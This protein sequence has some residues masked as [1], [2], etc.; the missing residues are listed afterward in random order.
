MEGSEIA[1]LPETALTQ[2]P[3]EVIGRAQVIANALAPIIEKQK[4]FTV[5]GGKKHVWVEGWTTMLAMLNVFPTVDF[6]RKLE[7][8]DE[9][10]YEA[11]VVLKFA[12][13]R[14][15]AAEHMCSNREAGKSGW[16]EY[17]VKSMAQTRAVGKAAR[18]SFSWIMSLAGYATTPAEEMDAA[19]GSVT[20]PRYQFGP[21][22]TETTGTS[23]EV[24]TI[25]QMA[26]EIK[27]W[28]GLMCN[29]DPA[30]MDAMIR[31]FTKWKAKD[32]GE[33][34]SLDL[35]SLPNIKKIEWIKRIHNNV[36]H[37]Y[38]MFATKQ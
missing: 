13:G 16:P 9:V 29:E 37:R 30:K 10:A 21:Q 4:L 5:I 31:D 38:T 36:S 24:K 20:V 25:P 22:P 15:F 6:V 14:V 26:A 35:N 12:D 1:V 3:A 7:R 23:G 33:E 19:V 2:S 34:K 11:R 18:L 28:I 32:T 8:P 27:S 17:A